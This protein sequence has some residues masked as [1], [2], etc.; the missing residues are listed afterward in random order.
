MLD[1]FGNATPERYLAD[2]DLRLITER[3]IIA[4]GECVAQAARSNPEILDLIPE[5][6]DVIGTRNRIAH[7]YDTI[8]DEV[9]WDIAANNDGVLDQFSSTQADRFRLST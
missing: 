9:V 5:T 8:R 1:R 4:V 3:L 6:L 2:R 7:D